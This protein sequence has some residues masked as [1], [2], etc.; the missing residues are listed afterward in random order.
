MK[1]RAKIIGKGSLDL[2]IQVSSTVARLVKVCVLRVC[3]DR[4]C[5]GSAG[6]GGLQE[7][8]LWCEVQQRAFQQFRME[9][10]SE[11]LNE[12]HLELMAE[13]LSRAARSAVG[14]SSLKL[15]LTHKR[16]PCL[17]VVVE[18][19]SPLG[20][21]RSVMHDLPVRVLPRRVWRDCLPP[22]LS[23]SDVSI[24]LPRWRTLRSIVE[25]MVNVGDHVLLEANLSGKMTLSIETEVVSIK[26]YFKN[27]GNPPKSA[28][29]VPQNRDLESMVQVRVDNRKLLQFLEGQQINP[30]TALC[31]IWDNALLHLVLVQEDVSL[32]YFIPAL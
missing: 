32:Q 20:R 24:Y 11:E 21:V 4:M 18:L 5:F 28:V 23:A 15:Q 6:S 14:A 12:I 19:A 27:L 10:V 29:G 13:H 1:F 16:C 25:R 3:P 17:T 31:N 8:R 22:S 9:G 7:A 30:P 26:S 2:F